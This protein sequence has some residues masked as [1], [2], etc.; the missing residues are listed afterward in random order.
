MSL[1]LCFLQEFVQGIDRA[2]FYMHRRAS[3]YFFVVVLEYIFDILRLD[4]HIHGIVIVRNDFAGIT[5]GYHVLE[6]GV[7]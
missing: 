4:E 5:F 2:N 3:A 1:F 7:G 6:F